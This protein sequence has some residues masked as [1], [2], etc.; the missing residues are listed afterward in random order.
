MENI[1]ED[2]KREYVN[3]YRETKGIMLAK[4]YDSFIDKMTKIMAVAIHETYFDDGTKLTDV[5]A[6]MAEQ[7]TPEA[8]KEQK[9]RLLVLLFFN[10]LD[11]CPYLMHEMAVH[12]YNKLRAE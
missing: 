3:H 4:D 10:A 7:Y 12:L 6:T 9:A 8:W 1:F 5:L 11:E 2:V